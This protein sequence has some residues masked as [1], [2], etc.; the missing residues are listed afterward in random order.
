MFLYGFIGV[1]NYYTTPRWLEQ[2]YSEQLSSQKK[3]S[4]STK[5]QLQPCYQDK[6]F[7]VGQP[8]I[9]IPSED[10]GW[11]RSRHLAPP[12]KASPGQGLR[13]IVSLHPQPTQP[14]LRLDAQ[15]KGER[16]RTEHFMAKECDLR[17]TSSPPGPPGRLLV[18][19]VGSLGLVCTWVT[20]LGTFLT[21]D[22][23]QGEATS[24]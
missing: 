2:G 4:I 10:A 18:R 22:Q 20:L 7:S 19:P 6:V 21:P 8:S 14:S 24:S 1:R 3:H 15:V 9:C 16:T 11:K 23:G 12:F 17:C 5:S 13:Q